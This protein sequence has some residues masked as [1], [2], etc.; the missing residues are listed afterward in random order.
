MYAQSM[1]M[2][3][4]LGRIMG[5]LT[6]Y[7]SPFEVESYSIAGNG[8]IL[9]G[10]PVPPTTVDDSGSNRFGWYSSISS[11]LDEMLANSSRSVFGETMARQMQAAFE[12]TENLGQ[13]LAAST[14]ETAFGGSGIE[15]QFE[16]VAKVIN[17]ARKGAWTGKPERQAF[18]VQQG[19]FDAHGGPA[20]TQNGLANID[21]ALSSFTTE[22]LVTGAWDDVVV[23]TASDFV[24]TH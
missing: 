5:V 14:T 23:L 20:G 4:V 22:M 18:F 2:S 8:L 7:D 12:A 16:Q 17:A 15:R 24:R 19:G 11:D 9:E 1:A 21:N 6:D 13:R 10:G 3:G